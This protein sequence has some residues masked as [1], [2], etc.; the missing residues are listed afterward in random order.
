MKAV[1]RARPADLSTAAIEHFNRGARVTRA[2][3]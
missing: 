2:V 1:G 3:L